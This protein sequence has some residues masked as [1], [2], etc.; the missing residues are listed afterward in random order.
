MVNVNVSEVDS[1][2]VRRMLIKAAIAT[3]KKQNETVNVT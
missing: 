1:D 2:S 3:H